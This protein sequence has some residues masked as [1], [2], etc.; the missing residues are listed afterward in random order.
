M[1]ISQPVLFSLTGK[2]FYFLGFWVSFMYKRKQQ[3]GMLPQQA[4]CLSYFK[5][6]INNRIQQVSVFDLQTNYF[7]ILK[8]LKN[9]LRILKDLKGNFKNRFKKY[10]QSSC[11][12]KQNGPE[13]MDYICNVF[14]TNYICNMFDKVK[15][16][17]SLHHPIQI[18][19]L[20]N[21]NTSF[22]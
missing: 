2:I 22:Q 17:F 18:I 5:K 4:R 15:M 20:S 10:F 8:E 7:G 3:Q 16:H 11:I 19:T 9:I 1:G 6:V 21:A 14:D 12:Y 13:W